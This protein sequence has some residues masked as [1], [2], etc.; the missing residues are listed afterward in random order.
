MKFTD[1]TVLITGAANGI[2][3]CLAELFAK[4]DANLIL[5]DIDGLGLENLN[6]KLTE[7][8][9]VNS[10]YMDVDISDEKE[11]IEAKYDVLRAGG[12]P[13]IIINNAGI[14]CNEELAKTSYK[15]IDRLAS[16][17]LIGPMYIC[18]LFLGDMISR[19]EGHIVNVS[20]G[21]AFF[22]LPTW[23]AYATTK[24]ALGAFSEA[25]GI[26]AKKYGI[27]VTTVYPFMV[28]TDFYTGME[29]G[30]DTWASKMAMKLLP[31]YSQSPETVAKRIMKAVIK[32]KEVEMVHPIN[33]VGYHLDTVPSVGR[34]IRKMLNVFLSKRN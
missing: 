15:D 1:K 21:Q 22:K 3:K 6:R 23:S 4:E 32:K 11:V 24:V 5:W 34:T 16:V 27:N 31:L 10:Y 18:Q 28:N 20:S 8:Y 12:C 19:K 13:D 14:G 17:N 29:A 33:W 26:E 9:S 30:A 25:L 2:G 7:K